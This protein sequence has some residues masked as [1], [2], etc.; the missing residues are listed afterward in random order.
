MPVVSSEFRVLRN[1]V[2]Y[3]KLKP[4]DSPSVSMT[5]DAEVKMTVQGFFEL[6]D[7]IN[8][9][10]DR[11]CPYLTIDGKSYQAGEFVITDASTQ[12]DSY[13]LKKVNLEGYDLTYLAKTSKIEERIFLAAGTKYTDIIKNL[14]V[15]S[16]IT[17][18][19]VVPNDAVLQTDREDWEPST[20]RLEIINT[21]LKEINYN[22][23]WMDLGGVV[24]ATPYQKPAPDNISITYRNDEYSLLYPE[25]SSAMDIFNKPNVF[26]AVVENPDLE[27]P[28]KAMSVNDN[29][30]NIFS[31]I[32]Q[33]RRILDYEK[34]DNIAG[35]RE[36]QDY[37][38]NKKFKS[39]MTSQSIEFTT[40]ANPVHSCFE[41]IALYKGD[42]TGIYEETGWELSFTP[43]NG[44]KHT[45]KKV[46]IL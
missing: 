15:E 4:T 35:Q 12:T 27:T 38:D 30:A 29:P 32:S 43:G 40:A 13:G 42:L 31:T 14:I 44:M 25:D 28:M 3:T 26:I 19:I 23:L 24:R 17:K 21:L 10:T 37:V 11:V 22:S 34:L 7:N 2:E 41:V 1:G 33:G 9:I 39:L 45:A 18:F 46:V 6:N 8:Y 20:E 36:L 16:G 5:A